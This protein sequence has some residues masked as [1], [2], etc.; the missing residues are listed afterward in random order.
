MEQESGVPVSGSVTTREL[1][2]LKQISAL[3]ISPDQRSAIVRIDQQDLASA[4]TR[5]TW[6]V[7]DFQSGVTAGVFDAGAPL[8]NANGG[9]AGETPRWS[10]DSNWIYFRKLVGQEVQ[11]W[12][13]RRD[14]AQVSQLTHDGADVVGF[15]VKADGALVYAVSGATRSQIME[16]EA[17]ERDRGVLMA[18][19]VIKGF[20]LSKGFPV[21]GRMATYRH[22]ES[23]S[24]GRRGTL[25][26]DQSLRVM[27]L[28]AGSAAPVTL[29]DAEARAFLDAHHLSPGYSFA[30]SI[31][32]VDPPKLDR[33]DLVAS[34][35]DLSSSGGHDPPRPRS[36]REVSWHRRDQSALSVSC[37]DPLCIEADVIQVIG[38]RPG[39]PELVLQT[40]ERGVSR[41]AIWNTST[42]LVRTIWEREGVIGSIESGVMGACQLAGDEAAC[43]T[44]S[45]DLPPRLVAVDLATKSRRT[46][47]DPNPEI[48][49][50]RLG[51][52]ST[53]KLSDR[54][55]N[56]TLGTLILPRDL[57][58]APMPLVITSYSCRGFLQGGSGRD[59][60]E[61]LLASLGYA[62]ICVDLGPIAFRS[63][64]RSAETTAALDLRALDFFENAVDVLA[65]AGIADPD[66]VVLS[67]YSGSSGATTFALTQSSKFTA[68]IVT[69]GGSLDAG[70]CY[71][72][73]NYGSC[74]ALATQL[75][76][77]VPFDARDGFL[78]SSPAWN[79]DKIRA[80]L[81]MQLPE[82]EYAG[83]MHLYGALIEYG[84][85]VEMYVFPAAY[86]YKH[87]PRQ[88]QTVYERNVDWINFWLRGIEPAGDDGERSALRWRAMRD[89]QCTLTRS[90]PARDR[91]MWYCRAQP[92]R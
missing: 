84:R 59:V 91:P 63:T 83:M 73:A 64:R 39:F 46:V 40:E 24:S 79:A 62:T 23:P 67:G 26:G 78:K 5:L 10:H 86:H 61:H 72:A 65:E 42:G 53:I 60:P 69:T 1:V 37:D 71:L 45:A 77:G 27:A 18:P 11:V 7:I 58:T 57:P 41:L 33:G 54:F 47:F 9:I 28:A 35:R 36:G 16:A 75:G 32:A 70:N 20:S 29:S 8:W 30:S 85:S 44:A 49:A 50:S 4:S 34:V 76:Y 6:R 81:L 48:T 88:R 90:A 66:R 74:Q 68:A 21:N 3:V 52:A 17:A 14:G 2:E 15:D 80:P 19:T 82:S 13:A 55:G 12:R 43:I 25:L 38:W 87:H 89:R 92:Q 51:V 22:I 31:A 56:E